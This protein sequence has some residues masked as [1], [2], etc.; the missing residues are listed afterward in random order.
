[1]WYNLINGIYKCFNIGLKS[2]LTFLMITLIFGNLKS[3]ENLDFS[4]EGMDFWLTFGQLG[5]SEN[6]YGGETPSPLGGTDIYGGADLSI[7]IAASE[8]TLVQLFFTDDPNFNTSFTVNAGT[9]GT[10][11]FD[12]TN[13]KLLVY[14]SRPYT[15]GTNIG[16]YSTTGKKTVRIVTDKPVSVY[17]AC[18]NSGTG[19]V[20]NLLP[21]STLGTSYYHISYKAY[22]AELDYHFARYDG[23]AVIATKDGTEIK[24]N[25]TLRATLNAGQVYYSYSA[26][27]G[28]FTGRLIT[29]NHP[30]S[31]F[32]INTEAR[33][34]EGVNT[35]ENLFQQM[36]PIN[37]WGRNFA[38]PVS[39]RGKDRVRIMASQGS[40]EITVAGSYSIS[41]RPSGTT[42]SGNT[43]RNIS[44]GTYVELEITAGCYISAN[45]PIGVCSYFVGNAAIPS[46]TV[47]TAGDP[48]L[49]WIPPVE[50]SIQS[51]NISPFS[52]SSVTGTVLNHALII[53]PTV[54]MSETTMAIGT[55][56][57]TP[58]T[59][60]RWYTIASSPYSYYDLPLNAV[61]S[62][63][64][65]NS[66]G[67]TVMGYGYGGSKSYYYLAGAATR[68]LNPHIRI[69]DNHYDDVQGM[70]YC[71]DNIDIQAIIYSK[72]SSTDYLEWYVNGAPQAQLDDVEEWNLSSL[73]LA[74]GNHEIRM[75]VRNLNGDT[76][77]C[78]YE[79][80]ILPALTITG[81]S[82]VCVNGT[83]ELAAT[84]TGGTW[85]SSDNTRATVSSSGTVT[86]IAA[87]TI[88]ITYQYNEECLTAKSVTVNALP[89][90]S[91]T[92]NAAACVGENKIYTTESSMSNYTWTVSGGVENT[93]YIKTQGLITD[94]AINITW[95]TSGTRTISVNYTNVNGCKA[96]SP[97][98]T[99]TIVT[100]LPVISFDGAT[101]VYVGTTKMLTGTPAGGSWSSS[102]TG[103][104]TIAANGEVTAI[105]EGTVTF[106]YSYNGCITTVDLIIL[107]VVCPTGE[108]LY[109][110]KNVVIEG[111]GSTWET[112]V[113]E[114]AD[115]FQIVEDCTDVTE[116][117]VAEGTYLPKYNASTGLDDGSRYV[118]FLLPANVSVY[119]GFPQDATNAT[120][121]AGSDREEVRNNIEKRNWALYPTIMSGDIGT[122]N[123]YSDN[124]FH[125]LIA[126]SSTGDIIVDG[127]VVTAGN[128]DRG[129]NRST[130]VINS[131]YAGG[132]VYIDNA[133]VTLSNIIISG[134]MTALS[135]TGTGGGLYI[136][137]LDKVPSLVNVTISGNLASE[138]AGIHI[139]NT[140]NDQ[141]IIPV[142]TNVTVAGNRASSGRAGGVFFE[143]STVYFRNSIIWGNGV[144]NIS[145]TTTSGLTFNNS[146]I[147]GSGG[148]EQ[149]DTDLGTDGGNNIDKDPLFVDAIDIMS[150]PTTAGNY[151]L[152]KCSPAIDKG[153]KTFSELTGVSYDLGGLSRVYED[154][155]I[156]MG[157]YEYQGVACYELF[158]T[159]FPFVK[160][161]D[162]D[163]DALFEITAS[164]YSVPALGVED[165]IDAILSGTPIHTAKAVFYDGSVF[166]AGTPKNPSGSSLINNPG[167]P[168]NWAL[169]NKQVGEI[170]ETL[171][172]KE[173]NIPSTPIGLY[174]FTNVEPGNYVLMLSRP[175]YVTRFAKVTISS[176][177]VL[178]HRELIPGDVD[179]NFVIN[180]Y[181]ISKVNTKASSYGNTNY[182]PKF[183]VNADGNVNLND[184]SVL[185]FYLG[186]YV[187]LYT[188]TESLILD[189][190]K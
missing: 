171:L 38:I 130:V 40:T 116:I 6:P 94:N 109:V 12:R 87:G 75:E 120:H 58:L 16:V 31:Y 153:D 61:A 137:Y 179:N 53:V 131:P 162:N 39:K 63:N 78:T 110:N 84:P 42:L 144:N 73:G 60:G 56:D 152:N 69:N 157:S 35:S 67:L 29:G 43:I 165:A 45:F 148:S 115:A 28:E 132:G 65:S 184:I 101:D 46:E 17:A 89:L 4:T 107:D 11:S 7:K 8:N 14:L 5:W 145:G 13:E 169:L 136:S 154:G 182:D 92:S 174:N 95:L 149:W 188:D 100:A 76:D 81:E 1:M 93:D 41:S 70:S 98:T 21:I 146:L 86:G 37:T 80:I 19:D 142:F 24:E 54:A 161:G 167:V 128:T 108:I 90:V 59:G 79:F 185:Q 105:L 156:D 52:M 18:Q 124:A 97:V 15:S 32:V 74:A 113:K 55:A 48:S 164:L 178:G 160:T 118:S 10:Y 88:N 51:T 82:S 123:N 85:L 176:D 143:N 135:S 71:T 62:Y 26:T 181:D 141:S 114:L 125:V 106:S 180:A 187:E 150:A 126:G 44:A 2:L 111:D 104:A 72:F 159:V 189:Y 112:A 166:V 20:S 173:A 22:S 33:I 77:I 96:A 9:I 138:G 30:F 129:A 177:G 134:N 151:R 66:Y 133:P 102:D 50:Q 57:A 36:A 190:Q 158:G 139:V 119:G 183:D 155:K 83:L 121:G 186:F 117:W 3:Q 34:P 122:P 64:F 172:T 27:N 140:G 175:G 168:I 47:A 25:G 91:V 23:Y 147:G 127:F 103:K 170:D 163:F 99:N 49:A 68:N